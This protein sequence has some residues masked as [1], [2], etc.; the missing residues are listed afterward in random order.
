MKKKVLAILLC[1]ALALF[2]VA[3]GGDKSTAPGNND[4][5]NNVNNDGGNET[6]VEDKDTLNIAIT[7]DDGT[8]AIEYMTSGTY[9]A[10]AVVMEQ[11]W[12]V[13]EDG[14]VI[15]VLAE[16]VEQPTD[17]EMIVHLRKDVKF[18]NGNPLTAEDVL[19]SIDL[20]KQAGAT[21]QPR[22]QTIDQEKTTAIDDHTVHIVM[23]APN[24]AHWQILSQFFVYDKESYNPDTVSTKPIGTGPYMVKEYVPNSV[25]K[26]ERN[27]NYWGQ[28]PDF[29]YLNFQVLNEPAQRVNALD[30]GI[31]DISPIAIE[32]SDYVKG[33]PNF[34]L[35]ERL[36][37]YYMGL[38]F[39]FG[40]K[41]FFHKN[42]DARR[43]FVHA[44]DPEVIKNVVYLGKAVIMHA[45]VPDI[46]F[47]YEDR[48]NNMDDTYKIGYNP[49]YAR[50]LAEK[51]G[52]SGQTISM[53]TN[54]SAEQTKAAEIVQ[55]MLKEINVTVEIR[56]YDPATA[57]QMAYD[58][59]ADHD[60]GILSGITPNRVVGDLLLNGV[61]YSP[62]LT[63]PGFFENNE[64]YLARAPLAMSTLD[65]AERSEILYDLLGQY[66]RN[67]LS[68]ALVNPYNYTAFS[69][70]ID[71]SSIRFSVGTGFIRFQDLKKAK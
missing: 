25:L 65:E 23:P 11:L 12:D 60:C 16:K 68:F 54:G 49:D 24:V 43:A 62:T 32:D 51:S 27:E 38:S 21:G 52:L 48:F 69:K 14:N 28:K 33:L 67:V 22:T 35:N 30:T 36:T 8:L 26:L 66:E 58:P 6:V 4:G 40:V 71:P 46:C 70:V 59:D 18:S 20:Y 34:H 64:E 57:W 2:M 53:I 13:D 44:V 37:G 63:I 9:S 5:S 42:P 55:S 47:D 1:L 19:F 3:C 29:K 56:S 50:Q 7:A 15:Y 10:M 39:N 41:S 61:R 31:V 17:S 45:A